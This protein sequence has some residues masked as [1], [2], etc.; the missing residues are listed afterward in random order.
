MPNHMSQVLEMIARS[1]PIDETLTAIVELVESRWT[2]GIAAIMLVEDDQTLRVGAGPRLPF[3]Y[4][5]GIAALPIAPFAASCG[6]AAFR[7]EPVFAADIGR[8]EAW[9]NYRDLA[10]DHGFG[11][12]W[13][14]PIVTSTDRLVGTLALYFRKPRAPKPDEADFATDEG[15]LAA[16]AIEKSQS[17]DVVHE[18]D[19]AVHEAIGRLAYE[20]HRSLRSIQAAL[21]AI[22]KTIGDASPIERECAAIHR[23]A[24]NIARVTESLTDAPSAAARERLPAGDAEV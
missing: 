17:D 1:A 14:V 13:S 16:I 9:V 6:T 19:H 3:G 15:L 22:S 4:V 12:C 20:L 24:I 2:D 7:R 10:R 11:A 21:E 23:E 8:H 5:S 18:H